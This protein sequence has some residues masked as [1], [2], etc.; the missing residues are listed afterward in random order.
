MACI[1]R[2]SVGVEWVLHGVHDQVDEGE[3]S[4]WNEL[5]NSD[6]MDWEMV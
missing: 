2:S 3:L 4:A 1:R 5:D 6:V